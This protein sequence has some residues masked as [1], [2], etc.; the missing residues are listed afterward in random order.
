MPPSSTLPSPSAALSVWSTPLRVGQRVLRFLSHGL[1]S[2]D[3]LPHLLE[4][5][6]VR[7]TLLF[8]VPLDVPKLLLLIPDLQVQGLNLSVAVDNLVL[9]TAD[10]HLVA[11]LQVCK[12][13]RAHR[14][15]H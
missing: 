8:H 1:E 2:L 5:L 4:L 9:M 13:S 12:L 14:L 6:P 7:S 11:L 15:G 10:A 3:L